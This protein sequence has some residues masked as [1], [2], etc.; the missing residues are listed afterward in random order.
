MANLLVAY[1]YSP[2]TTANYLVW[3]LQA[4]GHLVKC[5]GPEQPDEYTG[6]P[7]DWWPDALIWIEAGGGWPGWLW[8]L[9]LAD[10]LPGL[11]RAAWF[12]DSHS[13]HWHREFAQHFDHLFVAQRAYVDQ[14]DR[15]VT[16]L[17]VACDPEIHTP[18]PGIE[19]EHDVV[20]C[21]HLYAS[22]PL[23]ERRRRLLDMLG[24]RYSLGIYEGAYLKDMAI[25]HAKGRVVF[26]VSTNG[27]LNMRVFEALCSGRPL[28]T[29]AVPGAGLEALFDLGCGPLTYSSEAE[30]CERID[31]LL[32][33]P[34]AAQCIAA[35]GRLVVRM[36]HTYQHRAQQMLEVMGLGGEK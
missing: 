26:N 17:P 5:I 10:D 16:W 23:Y 2:Y 13:Q 20:F 19:P 18:P 12:I 36:D 32:A 35:S 31:W 28:V 11:P 33:N 15:P 4:L 21:G 27:D 34:V 6:L 3:A 24:K 9:G 25:A 29:D 30:L 14:F 7:A 1:R 8:S 22:S